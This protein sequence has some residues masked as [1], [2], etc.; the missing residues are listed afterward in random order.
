MLYLLYS[1]TISLARVSSTSFIL[2][3]RTG[4]NMGTEWVLR[5]GFQFSRC[6]ILEKYLPRRS[7][8]DYSKIFL[9]GNKEIIY[10]SPEIP[11]QT[12]RIKNK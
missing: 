11:N 8:P 12:V 2:L 3:F 5:L 7:Q 4:Y 6:K 1:Q 10:N 9:L